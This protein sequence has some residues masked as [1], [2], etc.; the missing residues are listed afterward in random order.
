VGRGVH[1]TLACPP[2]AARLRAEAARAGAEIVDVRHVVHS[3]DRWDVVHVHDGAAAVIGWHTAQRSGARLVR[4]QHFVRPA[5]VERTGWRRAASLVLHRALNADVDALVAVSESAA[6]AAL[7]RREVGAA[8]VSVIPPGIELPDE[9]QVERAVAARRELRDPVIAFVGRLEREKQLQ[10][11]LCAIPLVLRHLPRCTFA[12]AGSGSAEPELRALARQLRLGRSVR[13]LGEVEA[14][15]AVLADAHVYVHPC[16]GEGFGLAVAEAAAWALP[17]VG[18]DSGGVGELVED[19]ATGLLVPDDDPAEL[20][21]ALVRLAAD[22][23]WAEELGRE[24]RRRAVAGL[25]AERT[26]ALTHELYERIR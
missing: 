9:Q 11:L 15:D 4:T 21:A 12:I 24:G 16:A 13:W 22:R 5:T 20:A 10:L 25:G 19:E 7:E 3:R 8:K 2:A 1:V 18:R 17:V 14:P 23:E 6:A 26:A